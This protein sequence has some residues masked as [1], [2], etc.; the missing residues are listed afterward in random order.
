LNTLIKSDATLYDSLID[1]G[2]DSRLQDATNVT[3]YNADKVHLTDTG[4]GVVAALVAA[5]VSAL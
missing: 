1:L 5:Q 3:Y 2:A 4:Y